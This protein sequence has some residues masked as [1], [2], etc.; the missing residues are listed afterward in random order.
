MEIEKLSR[1]VSQKC[2]P[3]NKQINRF[4]RHV[5]IQLYRLQASERLEMIF[6]ENDFFGAQEKS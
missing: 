3:L 5:F 6:S 1:K 2:F 4:Y